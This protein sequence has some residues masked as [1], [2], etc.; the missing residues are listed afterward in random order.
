MNLL[1]PDDRLSNGVRA[2]A[3][4]MGDAWANQHRIQLPTSHYFQDID[5]MFGAAFFGKNTAEQLFVE[6]EPNHFKHKESWVRDFGAVAFF[7]RKTSRNAAYADKN[8]VSVAWYLWLC[9]TVGR[10]QPIPP[11]FFFVFGDANP[12]WEMLEID[13]ETG[14]STG[15]SVQLGIDHSWSE[16]WKQLGLTDIRN[17]LRDWVG[18]P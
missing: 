10:Y 1:P 9:R 5:A 8:N 3:D 12:P 13:I 17:T 2:R 4:G 11:K 16:L 14:R 7:D 6:Y 15:V 18:Q